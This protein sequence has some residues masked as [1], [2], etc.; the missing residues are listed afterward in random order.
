MENNL[1]RYSIETDREESYKLIKIEE[2]VEIKGDE[3][4]VSHCYYQRESDNELFEIFDNP[5][6][7]LDRDYDAYRNKNNLLSPIKIKQ[8]REEYNLSIRDFSNIFGISYSNLSAIENGAL[9]SKYLDSM[10][11]LASDP[12]AFMTLVKARESDLE[13]DKYVSLLRILESLV[14]VAYKEHENIAKKVLSYTL[15]IK[16]TL[17]VQKNNE[18]YRKVSQTDIGGRK[19]WSNMSKLGSGWRNSISMLA[20]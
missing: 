2:N 3:F 7:N 11:R 13:S 5:D 14:L 17:I 8:I 10:F 4:K 20:K 6:F 1:K 9:Q 12:Y 16:N 18:N 19:I 15:E